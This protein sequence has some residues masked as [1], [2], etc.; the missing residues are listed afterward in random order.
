MAMVGDK[1]SCYV[2]PMLASHRVVV[3][4]V[5]WER[6][7][8]AAMSNPAM[9]ELRRL[10]EKG[11]PDTRN[12]MGDSVREFF[13]FREDLSMTQG[14]ILFKDRVVIPRKLRK[15]ILE[16]LHA[17]HQGVVSMMARAANCVF[18]TKQSRMSEKDAGIVIT[19]LRHKQMN[20]PSQPSLPYTHF[21]KSAQT[22]VS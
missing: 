13:K 1:L 5:T 17:G 6:V 22:T 11:F 20:L 18:W 8:Q 4:A 3:E 7:Q 15:E 14:V 2:C 21:K 9:Q 16:V 12:E 10:L 19:L